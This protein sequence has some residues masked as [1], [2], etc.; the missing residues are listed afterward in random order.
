M[1]KNLLFRK[2]AV[3]LLLVCLLSVAL[4]FGLYS[5]AFAVTVSDDFNRADGALGSN[6]TTM[7]GTQAPQIAS[8]ELTASSDAVPNAAYWSAN[9]FSN[10]QFA[11]A[12][13]P[14]VPGAN[15]GPGIGVRFANSRG[16]FLWYGNSSDTVSIWRMDNPG[17]WT[18]IAASGSLTITN[19]DVWRIEAVGNTITGYQNGN[20]VV[21]VT[22]ATYANGS[23][24]V[25]L[26]HTANQIDDWSG[27]DVT[28]QY[29]V[30]GEVAGSDG[31][32]TLQDN[33]GDDLAVNSAGGFSFATQL[34][35]GQS[36]NV[37]VKTNP[38]NQTCTV[39]NGSGT[40]VS[41]DVSSVSVTCE[42]QNSAAAT[43]NFNRADGGL[44]SNWTDFSD[45]GMQIASQE[46]V[47]TNGAGGQSGDMRTG[48]T[49]SDDQFSEMEVSSTQLT[50][51][52]WVG[53]TTRTQ[54]SGQDLYLG[55]YDWNNGTPYLQIFK[56]V[57]G[58]WTVISGSY[59]C[60][61]LAPGTKLELM[62]VGTSIALLEN[63]VERETTYD[64]SL[65]SGSP[66][67]M[68]FGTPHLD[69]WS[70]GSTGFA[71]QYLSTD[72]NGVDKY[73]MLSRDD[74]FGPEELRV[75]N[76]TNPAPGVPH[77]FLFVLPVEPGEGSVQ[78]GNGL[79]TLRGLDAQN[80]YDLT[81]IEPSFA[82]DP[83]YADNPIS[84]ETQYESFVTSELEPWV[85]QH[86]STTGYEQNWLIGFSKSGIGGMDMLLK[87]PDLFSVGALWDFPADTSSYSQFGADSEASY[88]T[89][90]NFQSNY[91][92]TQSFL[93]DHKAPFT[94]DN[95]IWIGVY[96][97]YGN[98]MSDFDSLLTTLGF[99]HDTETPTAT[100]HSW[101]G[102]WVPGAVAAL[103]QLS[104]NLP[105]KTAPTVTNFSIASTSH[106]LS[107]P[108]T[109]FAAKDNIGVTGYKL[110]TGAAAPSA[111]ASGWA[112][113][114][115]GSYKFSSIGTK[116]LYAWVKDAAGNVSAS[117]NASVTI[118]PVYSVGGKVTGLS[119]SVT[120]KNSATGQ[121]KSVSKNG[122]F[123]FSQLVA[124]GQTYKISIAANPVNQVCT[125]TH[126]S[127]TVAASNITNVA[128]S[129]S[130]TAPAL[131][132][133]AVIA[134][135]Q[136]APAASSQKLPEK[137][138]TPAKPK[139]ATNDTKPTQHCAGSG[140]DS[141]KISSNPSPSPKQA[142]K[143][144]A[145]TPIYKRT[146]YVAAGSGISIVIIAGIIF[147]ILKLRSK[148]LF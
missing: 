134:T 100:T 138:P 58:S 92:L 36:Y 82:S 87:H 91:R 146:A 19:T 25:W 11:Q 2:A 84:A 123:A 130:S 14:S 137:K 107:V 98:D 22:D 8:D 68:A 83:W 147:A 89:E 35:A 132:S 21:Q 67:V 121:K 114:A 78:F 77:N 81:I 118:T 40:I 113:S 124:A 42:G 142:P 101:D 131:S 48:E 115:Q 133:K 29:S 108:I 120:L 70:G 60:G 96:S 4:V 59:N 73:N 20:Q 63:G 90:A 5:R 34:N 106:S 71:V 103:H 135:P 57:G 33:G 104:V 127:G 122:A 47:G 99:K 109:G 52:D 94:T 66:G 72:T 110:T 79:E 128:I 28:T 141:A 64:T 139:A 80:Q 46:V 24:G 17:S 61:A 30:G 145:Q 15:F 102:G 12:S 86:L 93:G 111:A 23:P 65:T 45:G 9:T 51:T 126:G 117:L 88:G 143:Q 144:Q 74:G 119:G 38:P 39:H 125:V 55:L 3:G 49:Y 16:Y 105:D 37:T 140:C 50:G 116:R 10:S 7:S 53:P 95:R 31:A 27:G 148:P 41:N 129:C 13:M 69:N 6:W 76:P 97:L 75:L 56:R 18:Q 136:P 1:V 85:Q 54:N 112:N 43:D 62:A 26:F 32:V 44:G